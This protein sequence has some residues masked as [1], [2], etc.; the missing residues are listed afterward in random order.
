MKKLFTTLAICVALLAT[1]TASAGTPVYSQNTP[2]QTPHYSSSNLKALG[3]VCGPLSNLNFTTADT[4][5]VLYSNS[6]GYLSGNSYIVYSSINVPTISIAEKFDAPTGATGRYVSSADVFFGVVVINPNSA[7]SML[8]VKAYI[9]DTTGTSPTNVYAPG[10]ALDSSAPMTL[11]AIAAATANGPTTFTFLHSTPLTSNGF[12]VTLSLT[13]TVGDTLAVYTNDGSVGDGNG[14]AEL[15]AA[16]QSQWITYDSLTGGQIGV[17]GNWIFPTVCGDTGTTGIKPISNI[18]NFNIYPNPSNGVF[19]AS[20]HMSSASDVY[21]SITDMTGTKVYESTE[22][23]VVSMNKQI[24]LSHLAAGVY[25]AS[26]KTAEG[27]SV[28]RLVIK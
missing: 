27:T 16:G 1:Y 18:N 13:Q 19:T 8:T 25:I 21:M 20:V 22:N 5:A 24:N 11:A 28:Q 14:W 4:N 17:L 23:A 6:Q 2:S 9:F 15:S 3:L 12:F 10:S 26:V 7:D